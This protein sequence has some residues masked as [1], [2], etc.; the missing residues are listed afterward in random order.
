[1]RPTEMTENEKTLSSGL[2]TVIYQVLQSKGSQRFRFFLTKSL[3]QARKPT[4]LLIPLS[5]RF[6]ETQ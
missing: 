4:L 1:M 6:T 5:S 2:G 3:C